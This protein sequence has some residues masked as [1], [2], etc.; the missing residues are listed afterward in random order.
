MADEVAALTSFVDSLPSIVPEVISDI[1]QGGEVVITIVED[2]VTDPGAAITIIENG[3]ESVWSDITAG[4]ASV[5][6][7]ITYFFGCDIFGDCPSFTD[8]GILSLCTSVMKA[9]SVTVKL[10]SAEPT[11]ATSSVKR[12]T[13]TSSATPKTTAS[14]LLASQTRVITTT[15]TTTPS[16]SSSDAGEVFLTQSGSGS[17]PTNA[18]SA[19]SKVTCE[20]SGYLK[21]FVIGLA[22]IVLL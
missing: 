5:I 2:L 8:N 22:L 3:V 12:T 21:L 16:S 10:T 11:T 9:Y 17:T 1:I 14:A 20:V 13:S 4:A 7:D 6:S 18:E 19:S 15:P